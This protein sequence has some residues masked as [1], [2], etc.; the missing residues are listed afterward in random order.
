MLAAPNRSDVPAQLN[1]NY[2][3]SNAWNVGVSVDTQGAWQSVLQPAEID[4]V[5]AYVTRVFYR[6]APAALATLDIGPARR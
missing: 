4:A 5:V 6:P 1:L 2:K 3:A